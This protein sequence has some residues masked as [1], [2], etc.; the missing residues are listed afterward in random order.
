MCAPTVWTSQSLGDAISRS[1][2]ASESGGDGVGGESERVSE[3]GGGGVSE[4]VGWRAGEWG[5]PCVDGSAEMSTK[6][7]CV[8]GV[9]KGSGQTT[10]RDYG[11]RAV[12]DY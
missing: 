2:V 5:R 11:W 3:C 7:S 12:N 10:A 6:E 4:R 1:S 9:F 8:V